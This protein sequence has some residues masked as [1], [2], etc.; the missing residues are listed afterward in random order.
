MKQADKIGLMLYVWGDPTFVVSNFDPSDGMCPYAGGN[1]A[2][3]MHYDDDFKDAGSLARKAAIYIEV[4]TLPALIAAL[5]EFL[6]P[7]P[8]AE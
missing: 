8:E 2:V 4:E 6:P 3:T 5:Q 1:L 7:P